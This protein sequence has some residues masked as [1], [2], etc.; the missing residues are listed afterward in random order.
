MSFS[1]LLP[2]RPHCWFTGLVLVPAWQAKTP[3]QPLAIQMCGTPS[4]RK[5][6]KLW[7]PMHLCQKQSPIW[8]ASAAHEADWLRLARARC[9]PRHPVALVKPARRHSDTSRHSDTPAARKGGLLLHDGSRA[10]R[11][12]AQLRRTPLVTQVRLL[13]PI[14]GPHRVEDLVSK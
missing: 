8:L 9:R 10:L 14:V 4:K 2:A 12:A 1:L 7:L 6:P 3:R 11:H 13:H 5:Q